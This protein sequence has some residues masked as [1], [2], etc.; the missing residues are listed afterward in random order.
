MHINS[1]ALYYVYVKL[2]KM[3]LLAIPL[4]LILWYLA[5]DSKPYKE[6]RI[7]VIWEKENIAKRTKIQQIIEKDLF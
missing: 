1:V 4:G 5:Y 6:D 7:G 3:E 2:K